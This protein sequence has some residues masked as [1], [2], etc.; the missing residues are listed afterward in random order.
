M[1]GKLTMNNRGLRGAGTIDYLAAS[2]TANDFV[3]YPD[4]VTAKGTDA[5]LTRSTFGNVTF[6]QALLT[7]EMKWYTKRMNEIKKVKALCF[8]DSAGE[9]STIS[10]ETV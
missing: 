4:S 8:Y 6:P 1:N 10:F 3:Y 2:V 5:R 9:A 7:F